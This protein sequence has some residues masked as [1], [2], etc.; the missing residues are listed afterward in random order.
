MTACSEI[1]AYG[2]RNPFRFTID[3]VSE[4]LWVGDV[5]QDKWEEVDHVTSGGNYGWSACEGDHVFPPQSPDVLCTEP[6]L[7]PRAEY[8]HNDSPQNQ[9]VTGGVIYR[10]TSMPELYGYY[11]YADF[12]SGNVWA[13]NTNDSSDAIEI[14]SHGGHNI[15]DFVLAANGEVYMLDYSGGLYRLSR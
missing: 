12:Y 8:F 2:F 1:F 9:A 5:G 4:Q 13:V 10:G 6:Y 7:L 14:T 3:P 15:S 11:V